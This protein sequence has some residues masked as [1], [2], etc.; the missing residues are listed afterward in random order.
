[1]SK[2]NSNNPP[3]RASLRDTG[4]TDHTQPTILTALID[5]LS[6]R[7][8]PET[9]EI[10]E[11]HARAVQFACARWLAGYRCSLGITITELSSYT[12][13]TPYQILLFDLG[14]VEAARFTESQQQRLREK[15]IPAASSDSHTLNLLLDLALGQAT[16]VDVQ[17]L[18]WVLEDLEQNV[19]QQSDL[20][21]TFAGYIT[22]LDTQD[23]QR[24][25]KLLRQAHE[26]LLI[27]LLR[28][29]KTTDELWKDAVR[30]LQGGQVRL[31]YAS[32][33]AL[34]DLLVT[35]GLVEFLPDQQHAS[36][37]RELRQLRL[38]TFGRRVI[39]LQRYV[40]E[41][42]S[43]GRDAVREVVLWLKRVFGSVHL[44]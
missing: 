4:A 37:K 26:V 38:T 6:L 39:G 27:T 24:V 12:E 36:T 40:R 34:I 44:I 2:L 3:L 19:W 33:A 9:E 31:D 14:L 8:S 15:L 1:M 7:P 18:C 41:A 20:E 21:T 32:Y 30:Q 29:T 5:G 35:N 43:E 16:Q 22:P 23:V 25:Q 28:G 42:Q 13:L 11:T 10:A 17:T